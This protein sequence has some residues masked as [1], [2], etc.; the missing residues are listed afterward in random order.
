M[1]LKP[2]VELMMPCI[3]PVNPGEVM[4]YFTRAEYEKAAEAHV[5]YVLDVRDAFEICNGR[6]E[7]LRAYYGVMER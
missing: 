3:E 4:M 1:V 7:A 5:R 2:P 6:F